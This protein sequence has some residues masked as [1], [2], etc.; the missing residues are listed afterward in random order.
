MFNFF[1]LI[2]CAYKGTS[3]CKN[4]PVEGNSYCNHSIQYITKEWE[5][6]MDF[7]DALPKVRCTKM[8]FIK[9][10]KKWIFEEYDNATNG[11]ALKK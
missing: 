11:E 5:E 6:D 7:T 4:D 10:T 2:D 8:F 9:I 1:S 3:T